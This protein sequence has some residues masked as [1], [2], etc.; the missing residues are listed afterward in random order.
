MGL[1]STLSAALAGVR[2]AQTGLNSVA[3]NI[4]SANAPGYTRK[5]L[6]PTPRLAG[7][8]VIGVSSDSVVRVL[9][10]LLQR[11][12]RVESGGAK[13]AD[14]Q[15]S[16]LNRLDA[17]YGPPG[18]AT[19][20]DS[21][22]SAFT[23][24]LDGLVTSPESSIAQQAALEKGKLLAGRINGISNDIQTMREEAEQGIADNI[25]QMNDL[26][27]R[28]EGLNR[29]IV[30]DSSGPS[31][32]VN[33]MDQRDNL[34]NELAQLADIRVTQLSDNGVTVSTI[35]GVLLFDREPAKLSFDGRY[36]FT[37]NNLYDSDPNKRTVGTIT[38][39]TPGGYQSDL[40]GSKAFQSGKIG[41][42]IALRD[43]VLVE[44]Q[45]QLDE[46]AS[47]MALAISSR[48]E[49][50]SA[51]TS[52][53]LDGRAIDLAGLGSGDS[54]TLSVSTNG[55]AR[56]VTFVRVDDASQL[57]LSAEDAAGTS[58]EVYG[59]D[60]TNLATAASTI[61]SILGAGFTASVAGTTLSVLDDG[62]GNTTAVSA[63]S[64]RISAQNLASDEA[65]LPF[66][67]DS[68][69]S[70]NTYT[71]SLEG[72]PQK[73]GFSGRIAINESLLSD[74][75]RLV[76]MGSGTFN[77]GDPTRP[78]GILDA[79]TK[80]V[81]GFAPAAGLTNSSVQGTVHSYLQRIV[82]HV[83]QQSANA[84]QVKEGQAIVVNGL[85]DRFDSSSKVNVDEEISRMIQ[86]QQTYQASAKIL[87]IANAMLEQLME[88]GR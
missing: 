17:V 77:A 55:V 81:S 46:L 35:T 72:G 27:K 34:L 87:A 59:V 4:A 76:N 37:A 79:L 57:P 38:L 70:P 66:F 58:G 45:A 47:A 88:L 12:L 80:T 61:Q 32:P 19:A 67:I 64:A 3:Q 33:L 23:T 8:Q 56:I 7:G 6:Q 78:K 60:F 41:A 25:G 36:G 52:G 15:Q 24:A 68:G 28:L 42:Y 82:N 22:F 48:T 11:Q 84:Q 5:I 51:T 1:S 75:A 21:M 29:Q 20:L 50:S 69:R 53:G 85:Q 49:S 40:I 31:D 73:R 83:G 86:L 43:E 74:P 63:A 30:A 18:S 65:A 14:V 62:A 10:T 26:L 2:V 71:A 39:T 16:Y 9:D 54:L 13:Y 44:A